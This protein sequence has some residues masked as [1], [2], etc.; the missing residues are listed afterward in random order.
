LGEPQNNKKT[1]SSMA[2]SA[3]E[4]TDLGKIGEMKRRSRV[5]FHQK[6]CQP[7]KFLLG[8][9]QKTTKQ[10]KSCSRRQ[11]HA[12]RIGSETSAK[13]WGVI[14]TVDNSQ[15]ILNNIQTTTTDTHHNSKSRHI[16]IK[17]SVD[18]KN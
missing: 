12:N 16:D 6:V 4:M 7:L 10:T 5:E 11:A 2:D 18:K 15:T 8:A 14:A 3:Q 1:L 17:D 13:K 9:N